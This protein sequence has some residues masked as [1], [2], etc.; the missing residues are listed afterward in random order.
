MLS[1]F[2]IKTCWSSL[3]STMTHRLDFFS[4]FY[5]SCYFKLHGR[6]Y[7]T[8]DKSQFSVIAVLTYDIIVMSYHVESLVILK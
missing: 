5:F 2:L 1:S 4:L 3:L 6:K 7:D 8:L